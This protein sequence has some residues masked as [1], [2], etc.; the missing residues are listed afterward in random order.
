MYTNNWDKRFKVLKCVYRNQWVESLIGLRRRRRFRC[1]LGVSGHQMLE[2]LHNRTCSVWNDNKSW[3]TSAWSHHPRTESC[4][5]ESFWWSLAL[6]GPCAEV[7]APSLTARSSLKPLPRPSWRLL[8]LA[9][10]PG[11]SLLCR[12]FDG[13][14]ME[15]VSLLKFKTDAALRLCAAAP[16]ALN[17]TKNLILI[18]KT[19][20]R[21]WRGGEVAWRMKG[22]PFPPQEDQCGVREEKKKY[23]EREKQRRADAAGKMRAL[24]RGCVNPS[25]WA[26]FHLIWD[27][28]QG[29]KKTL[30][31]FSACCSAN[32]ALWK[33]WSGRDSFLHREPHL[34]SDWS[35]LSR[36]SN[37][38]PLHC[39]E[40]NQNQMTAMRTSDDQTIQ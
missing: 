4:W 6:I 10:L 11:A 3:R 27:I 16:A 23:E 9:G 1:K 13:V 19:K 34:N 22:L 38:G 36:V 15:T 2:N 40:N 26:F 5:A 24:P 39:G 30:S 28:T 20:V 8:H 33:P 12:G 7:G 21:R 25:S 17:R 32:C 37:T 31:K 29:N 35:R 14:L 18:Y